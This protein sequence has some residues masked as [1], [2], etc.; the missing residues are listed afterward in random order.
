MVPNK[1]THYRTMINLKES[2]PRLAPR[3]SGP[4]TAGAT[5]MPKRKRPDPF[6]CQRRVCLGNVC[7]PCASTVSAVCQPC[8]S[9][10][11]IQAVVRMH[12]ARAHVR[13]HHALRRA[14]RAIPDSPEFEPTDHETYDFDMRA[15]H[16]AEL[17]TDSDEHD[18]VA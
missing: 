6:L 10:G 17:Q 13:H 16:N 1:R 18:S 14:I 15:A 5:S 8:A 7:T 9:A 2:K 4:V 3:H 11:L 12:I